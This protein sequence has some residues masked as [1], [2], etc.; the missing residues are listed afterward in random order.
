MRIGVLAMKKP[1]MPY[2]W[3]DGLLSYNNR[4]VIPPDSPVIVQRIREHHDTPMGVHSGVFHTLKR[5]S[6]QF[7]WQ[8]MLQIVSGYV[9]HCDLCQ[10]AKSRTLSPAGHLQPLPIPNRV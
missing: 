1:W 3:N 4:V 10:R 9:D 6:R 2:A 8:S 5:W 7:Y